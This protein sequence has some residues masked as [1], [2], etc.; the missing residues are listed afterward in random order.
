MRLHWY[1]IRVKETLP[2]SHTASRCIR[3]L[4]RIGME[5]PLAGINRIC[6]GLP[7]FSCL[8]NDSCIIPGSPLRENN[9]SLCFP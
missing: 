6:R 2:D 9:S 8:N 5:E 1:I 4:F 7:G 3:D